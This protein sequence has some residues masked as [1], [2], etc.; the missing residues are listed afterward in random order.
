MLYTHG[1]NGVFSLIFDLL[2]DLVN[3]DFLLSFSRSPVQLLL[4]SLLPPF[5]Q[6]ALPLHS[7][8]RRQNILKIRWHLY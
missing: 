4:A 6:S 2:S 5:S 3:I 7:Y 1:V 8:N